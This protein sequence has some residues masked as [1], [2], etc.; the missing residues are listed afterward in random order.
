[1]LGGAFGRLSWEHA[2]DA[3]NDAQP[4]D[5]AVDRVIARVFA[6]RARQEAVRL[7]RMGEFDAARATLEAT[8][9]R[10]RGYAGRDVELRRIA[11]ELLAEARM[12][13]GA[14]P[15]RYRKER[16]AASHYA[17]QSRT[18]EGAAIRTRP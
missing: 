10:I 16:F 11:D 5:R 15:E 2:D 9:R 14:L 3:A 12:F 8:A 4:R 6:A 13:V 18:A 7:N 1:V 17:L